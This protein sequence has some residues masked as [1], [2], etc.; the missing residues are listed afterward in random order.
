MVLNK[1]Y[2]QIT[3]YSTSLDVVQDFQI[4]A[5]CYKLAEN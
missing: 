1:Q 5:N 3:I 4:N 2:V